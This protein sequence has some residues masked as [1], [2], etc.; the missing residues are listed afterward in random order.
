MDSKADLLLQTRLPSLCSAGLGAGVLRGSLSSSLTQPPQASGNQRVVLPSDPRPDRNPW[1]ILGPSNWRT[2]GSLGR[3]GGAVEEQVLS[4][5]LAAWPSQGGKGLFHAGSPHGSFWFSAESG[6]IPGIGLG[7]EA[8]D[9]T[10][11]CCSAPSQLESAFL[12]GSLEPLHKLT[13]FHKLYAQP[14]S[15]A[16]LVPPR[17]QR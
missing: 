15:P 17:E 7:R 1:C 2:Q 16:I 8:W 14:Q 11:S 13:K 10:P 9:L 4:H 5:H 3:R 6:I 12:Q